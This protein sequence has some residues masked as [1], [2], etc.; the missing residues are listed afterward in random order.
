MLS[1]GSGS[2]PHFCRCVRSSSTKHNGPVIIRFRHLRSFPEEPL[3]INECSGWYARIHPTFCGCSLTC[4]E[5]DLNSVRHHH[6]LRYPPTKTVKQVMSFYKYVSFKNLKRILEGSIRFTQPGALNDPF[7]MVPELRVPE[8]FGTRELNIQF[9]VTAPRREP[10]EGAPDDEFEPDEFNDQNSRRILASLNRTIGTLCLSKNGSSL[11]MWS[12][13]ADG[14][15]GG[16]VEFDAKHEF[17]KGFF[18][19]WYSDRRPKFEIT[20]YTEGDDIHPIAELCVKASEWEYEKEVRI[21]RSLTDCRCVG[22]TDGFPVY[23][24]DVPS[25]CIKS[26]IL[27]ER[28]PVCNQRKIWE[29]VKDMQ[30]VSLYLDAVSDKGYEFRRE[31]I[32][33][34]GMENPWISPRTAN[35][36]ADNAGPLGEIARWMLEKHPLSEVVNDTL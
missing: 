14:Y 13:Y 32:K 2:D 36:F 17:F 23:V 18:E 4:L 10:L 29:S 9:S 35:I 7:E 16:V 33:V 25:D 8:D 27:G 12:H 19:I 34:V 31:P 21:V 24:M 26:V 22:S 1:E 6:H 15:S 11:T 30:D 28:M 5:Y 20:R 3:N